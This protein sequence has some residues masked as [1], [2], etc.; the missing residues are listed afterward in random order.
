MLVR[1]DVAPPSVTGLFIWEV[2]DTVVKNMPSKVVAMF[3]TK[4]TGWLNLPSVWVFVGQNSHV[5]GVTLLG[6]PSW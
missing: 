4:V 1:L 6:S 3:K 5:E 2:A